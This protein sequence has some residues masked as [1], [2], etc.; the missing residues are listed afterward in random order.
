MSE[1]DPPPL[2]PFFFPLPL[3]RSL[4]EGESRKDAPPLEGRGDRCSF[5][6]FLPFFPAP[7]PVSKEGR[8][9]LAFLSPPSSSVRASSVIRK[10]NNVDPRALFPPPLSSLPSFPILGFPG[11]RRHQKRSG[12][13]ADRFFFFPLILNNNHGSPEPRASASPLPLPPP[14][15]PFPSYGTDRGN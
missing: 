15:S 5:P 11:G 9:R 8:F 6:F 12:T 13:R 2:F 14:L 1:V 10:A 4:E 7:L 3:M